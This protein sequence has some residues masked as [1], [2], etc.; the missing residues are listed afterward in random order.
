MPF[1]D[2]DDLVF[3]A[4]GGTGG[5]PESIFW[6]K[7]PR[8][9]GVANQVTV[10][11][12]H[13]SLWQYDGIPSGG[14]V[15]PTTA[16]VPTNA[17]AGS[18]QQATTANGNDRFITYFGAMASMAGTVILGDRLLHISGLS[19][20]S[21]SVQ[22]VGGTLTRYTGTE[23]RGNEAWAE[24][25][26]QIGATART[27]TVNYTN[28]AGNSASSTL[29]L[30]GTGIREVQRMVKLP[31]ASGDSG[32]RAVA[33]V[34]FDNSTG[35]QGDFGITI[36]RPLA[37]IPIPF[38]GGGGQISFI[39]KMLKIKSD[40]CLSLMFHANSTTGPFVTIDLMIVE[41]AQ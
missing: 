17:T 6:Q 26:T 18:L 21:T 3:R 29:P 27:L 4:S 37:Q 23:S 19:G 28:Q 40:A 32:V 41:A 30:G 5:N 2:L 1:V 31:L 24:I 33:S 9:G 22:T 14:A 16:A 13:T 11:A 10:A 35:T 12:R 20:T 8:I 38:A 34:Q 39:D 7:D 25:Y 36:F 15:P